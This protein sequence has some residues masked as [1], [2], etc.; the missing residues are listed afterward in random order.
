M[1]F[2]PEERTTLPFQLN[3]F[4][5]LTSV[6]LFGVY[7]EGI[8]IGRLAPFLHRVSE[9]LD[10]PLV[11][12]PLLKRYSIDVTGEH[13]CRSTGFLRCGLVVHKHQSCYECR[14]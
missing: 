4:G 10:E 9:R 5:Q 2:E 6:N 13:G 12:R 7:P 1:D 11:A 8:A 3:P 14:H